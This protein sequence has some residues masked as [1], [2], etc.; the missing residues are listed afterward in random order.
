MATGTPSSG[1]RSPAAWRRS[2][3]AASARAASWR[4]TRKAHSSG[5]AASMAASAAST[6][7]ADVVSPAAIA[8]AWAARPAQRR[9]VAVSGRG[10][11][12]VLRGDRG[13]R[14]AQPVELV[15]QIELEP[16]RDARRQRGDDDLVEALHVDG[17]LDRVERVRVADH[18]LDV[19]AGGL[20]E[21][22]HGEVD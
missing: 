22:R 13:D 4:T 12:A 9:S 3:S 18:G 19:A 1:R 8:A 11:R 21:Q 17:V 10:A 7:A 14:Q 15:G 2:A 20:V 5:W 16:A 6:S